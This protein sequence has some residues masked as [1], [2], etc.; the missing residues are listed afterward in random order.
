[1]L[2][3][4]KEQGIDKVLVDTLEQAEAPSITNIYDFGSEVAAR[5]KAIRFAIL[6]KQISDEKQEFLVTVVSNRG[7]KILVFIDRAEAIKWL[8]D[9]SISADRGSGLD[10]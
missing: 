6:V 7:G 4:H 1:M 3:I 9:K 10:I 5:L 8:L 2:H